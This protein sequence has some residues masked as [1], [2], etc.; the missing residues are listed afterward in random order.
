MRNICGQCIANA[1]VEKE[2]ND[3][4]LIYLINTHM[5]VMMS[6]STVA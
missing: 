3:V 6:Q 4:L 1:Y 5:G 2:E